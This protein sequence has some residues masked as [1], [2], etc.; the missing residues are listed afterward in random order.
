MYDDLSRVQPTHC[1]LL[2]SVFVTLFCTAFYT[3]IHVSAFI[4]EN[5]SLDALHTRKSGQVVHGTVVYATR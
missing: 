5:K 2:C 1:L 4:T 3:V